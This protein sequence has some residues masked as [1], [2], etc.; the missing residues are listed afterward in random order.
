M[1]SN[2]GDDEREP[3]LELPTLKLPG[4]GR[5]KKNSPRTDAVDAHTPADPPA[6]EA[7]ASPGST[8]TEPPAPT[9]PPPPSSSPGAPP[10]RDRVARRAARTTGTG[11]SLPTMPGRAAAALTGVVVGVSG[12]AA[13]WGAM[14]GCE[15]VRGVST[16]GGP[17]GFLILVTI[18]V[19]MILFGSAL[20][21]AMGVP[22]SGSTSFLAVGILAVVSML[23]LLDAIFSA[24]M[25]L[26][27]PLLAAAAYLVAHW[28]TTRF[29]DE[30]S[31]RRDWT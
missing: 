22:G 28:V 5:R 9:A 25:F 20:L 6:R 10:E 2:P 30:P 7:G 8:K 3:S 18:L 31:G 27:V 13:T 12:A 21:R 17:P 11:L 16:C 14:A 24:W 15:A 29:E 4:L 26:V 1:A 23:V 19:L